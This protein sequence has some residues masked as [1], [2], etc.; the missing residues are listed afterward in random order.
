MVHFHVSNEMTEYDV[1]N[2]LTKIYEL[3]VVAVK[4]EMKN[5]KLI[6]HKWVSY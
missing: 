3:P 5:G 2:Y 6:T 1:R 4:V